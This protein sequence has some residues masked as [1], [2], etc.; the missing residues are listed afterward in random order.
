MKESWNPEKKN[1]TTNP[2][3]TLKSDLLSILLATGKGV[4]L[5]RIECM[6]CSMFY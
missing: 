6:V 2:W 4:K 5:V 1:F 3:M